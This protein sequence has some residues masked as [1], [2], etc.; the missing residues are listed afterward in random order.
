MALSD[1]LPLLFFI[2]NCLFSDSNGQRNRAISI[3]WSPSSV[4]RRRK[5]FHI[6]IYYCRTAPPN[7]TNLADNILVSGNRKKLLIL[8]YGGTNKGLKYEKLSNLF[9][10]KYKV[11]NTGFYTL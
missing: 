5:L 2:E 9:I 8:P 10:I 7:A 11:S 4:V 1:C 6:L 3:T